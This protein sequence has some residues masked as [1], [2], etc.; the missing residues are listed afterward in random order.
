MAG[1]RIPL[2]VK[3][4]AR[5]A[6]I[7]GSYP[8]RYGPALVVAVSSPAVDGRATEAALRAVANALE[9]P[10]NA[11]QLHSGQA[12]RD[13]LITIEQPP[14]NLATQLETLLSQQDTGPSGSTKKSQKSSRLG[15]L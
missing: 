8:G 5:S 13:K 2:R 1:V 6:R 7:G 3:P 11:I 15:R 10:R 4:S 12:S 14:A 9:I